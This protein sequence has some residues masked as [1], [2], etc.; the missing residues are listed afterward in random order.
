M[1]EFLT[2]NMF[3]TSMNLQTTT[4]DVKKDE[5]TIP[6]NESQEIP[7]SNESSSSTTLT[8]ANNE[9]IHIQYEDVAIGQ[10]VQAICG[11]NRAMKSVAT[12]EN[13]RI[14]P[15]RVINEEMIPEKH[16][17]YLNWIESAFPAWMPI[18]DCFVMD[19]KRKRVNRRNFDEDAELLRIALNEKKKKLKAEMKA[20]KPNNAILV[21]GEYIKPA[22]LI[23]EVTKDI[24]SQL[25]EE[26][27]AERAL[28]VYL[29]SLRLFL[30]K[31]IVEKLKSFTNEHKDNMNINEI[32]RVEMEN[33]ELLEQPLGLRNVKMRNYQLKGISWLVDRYNKGINCILADEMGKF[34]KY[35]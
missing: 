28:S 6:I 31:P 34:T 24:N 5:I 19:N 21:D 7:Q 16:E 15:A 11:K 13:K 23:D 9:E 2:E 29:D 35:L 1:Y 26:C 33:L 18:S 30:S 25:L 10:M 27:V 4:N 12:V 17:L 32:Y 3:A 14:I 8:V 20:R 22:K